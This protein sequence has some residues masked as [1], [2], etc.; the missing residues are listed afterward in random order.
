[1]GI[2][3]ARAVAQLRK[4]R[5]CR[6]AEICRLDVMELL[7]SSLHTTVAFTSSENAQH[8]TYDSECDK[9][10][11]STTVTSW[12]LSVVLVWTVIYRLYRKVV[13]VS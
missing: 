12:V 9:H 5:R 4:L 6:G 10:V 7:M 8:V 13:S 3:L 11:L 2:L 1:V